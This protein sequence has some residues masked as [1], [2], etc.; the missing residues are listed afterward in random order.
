[1]VTIT[2]WY[3]P[4]FYYHLTTSCYFS[5]D[6]LFYH[7]ATALRLLLSPQTAYVYS[8]PTFTLFSTFSYSS[9]KAFIHQP[10]FSTF[11]KSRTL[12]FYCKPTYITVAGP[13]LL[14]FSL[15]II[16]G[17]GSSPST[18]ILPPLAL[19]CHILSSPKAL[20]ICIVHSLSSVLSTSSS[21]LWKSIWIWTLEYKYLHCTCADINGPKPNSLSN[22]FQFPIVIFSPL[23]HSLLA[24]IP[25]LLLCFYFFSFINPIWLLHLH[26]MPTTF[27]SVKCLSLNATCWVILITIL[28]KLLVALNTI[29]RFINLEKT[30]YKDTI[31]FSLSSCF[32]GFFCW[33]CKSLSEIPVPL[34]PVIKAYKTKYSIF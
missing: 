21:P 3:L 14:F 29:N 25:S 34:I 26:S 2:H 12:N 5:P 24:H 22:P 23:L 10:E 4:T 7:S 20:T 16:V 6:N 15:L 8:L 28:L 13:L 18:S 9:S 27:T 31:F 1:M 30:N 33:H 19:W 11:L 32:S 17:V